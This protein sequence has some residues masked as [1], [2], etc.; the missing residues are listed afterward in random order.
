MSSFGNT[1]WC[2]WYL[3]FQCLQKINEI[4]PFGVALELLKCYLLGCIWAMPKGSLQN[5]SFW[6]I[7]KENFWNH[8][9]GTAN[10]LHFGWTF[11]SAKKM[12]HFG[13]TMIST[14]FPFGHAKMFHFG[15]NFLVLLKVHP[16]CNILVVPKWWFQNFSFEICKKE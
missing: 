16:N 6:H 12:N 1:F 10:M 5:D 2:D 11:G 3:S 14:Q 4:L 8:C 13:M 15:N 7:S 9:F